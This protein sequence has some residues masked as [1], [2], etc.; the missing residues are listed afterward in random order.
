[1]LLGLHTYEVFAKALVHAATLSAKLRF[2][3]A[4]APHPPGTRRW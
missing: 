4:L 3:S 2:P 1:M